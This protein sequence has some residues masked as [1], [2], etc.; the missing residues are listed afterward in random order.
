MQ[1]EQ[2]SYAKFSTFCD[3]EQGSLKKEIEEGKALIESLSAS[4]QKATADAATLG[5]EIAGLNRDLDGYESD[6][7]KQ[8]ADREATHKEFVASQ[9]DL[10]ESVDALSRAIVILKRQS[11][12]RKQAASFLQTS[13]EIPARAKMLIADFMAM[14]SEQDPDYMAREAPEANAYEFQGGG[15][16][17][18]L[19]KL[20][21]KFKKELSDTEMAETRSRQAFEMAL[22]DLTAAVADTK[23][24]TQKKTTS[25]NKRLVAKGK[26]EKEL[27]VA[28]TTLKENE[29]TLTDLTTECHE[30]GLSYEEKQK[31]SQDELEA[32]GEAIK[33]LSSGA[34]D[35]MQTSSSTSLLQIS[36]KVV[37]E[38]KQASDVLK[39]LTEQGKKIHSEKLALLASKLTNDP[40]VKV[41]KMIK[42]MVTKLMNEQNEEAETKGFCDKELRTNKMTRDKL[43]AQMDQL[44]A[45]YD[46]E[47]AT[48]KQLGELVSKLSAEVAAS[49]AAVKE[50]I[51]QRI[52]ENNKNN[53]T[54]K[55]AKAAQQ[56]VAAATAVLKEFYDKAA[57][58]TA[59]VQIPKMGSDEWNAL[60]NPNFEGGGAGYGQGSEDKVDKGH[61]AGMQTFGDSSQGQ[62]DSAHGVLAMLEV[63]MSDFANLETE[64]AT[65]EAESQKM[66]ERFVADS[67]KEKMVKNKQIEMNQADKEEAE[68]NAAQAKRDLSTTDDQLLAADRYYESLKPKCVDEGVSFEERDAK[69]KEEIASLKEALQ[70]LQPQE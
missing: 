16:V 20:Q 37:S 58:A 12:D 13:K 70:M 5:D 54:I 36:S 52:A 35:Y 29:A 24:S 47:S 33:I 68:H 15:I 10:S 27:G 42:A 23:E 1:Q 67:K 30:K 63:I 43:A 53:A 64:T 7:A 9:R 6:I 21:T 4:V 26:A 25:R 62:Q 32:L 65:S 50:A 45:E 28:Q 39:F 17:E 18:M 49:D 69:R 22:Q 51:D 8:K 61:K 56:A 44:Q 55:D 41:K 3:N 59:F 40:F 19:K 46:E 60:A 11:Y 66:H 31:L 2:I 14:D 38:Q 34:A 57:R 48:A